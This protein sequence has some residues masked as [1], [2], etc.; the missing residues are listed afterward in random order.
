MVN[1]EVGDRRFGPEFVGAMR[2]KY[3]RTR[4]V[5]RAF[6]Y[7]IATGDEY[8]PWREWFDDQLALL[9]SVDTAKV[10][11]RLWV[12]EHF[13]PT[14]HELATGASL[15]AAGLQVL[16]AQPWRPPRR[17][18]RHHRDG[19][20]AEGG[21]G[22]AV[23]QPRA[24][25]GRGD[26]TRDARDGGRS[27]DRAWL[28]TDVRSR[29]SGTSGPMAHNGTKPRAAGILPPGRTTAAGNHS[30]NEHPITARLRRCR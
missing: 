18:A 27:R 5:D 14:I 17:P 28:S 23:M 25:A 22:Q 19:L 26:R 7:P 10:A 16:Y 30:G 29:P 24:T 4:P 11:G 21:T 1:V 13:W 3:S 12:D 8:E 15:R 20:N 6:W 9:P 2:V